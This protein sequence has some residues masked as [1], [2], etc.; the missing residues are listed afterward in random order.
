MSRTIKKNKIVRNVKLN[1]ARQIKIRNL[2]TKIETY[3]KSGDQLEADKAFS[4]ISNLSPYDALLFGELGLSLY[5][6]GRLEES[7]YLLRKV[8]YIKPNMTEIMT[9]LGDILVFH[10]RC[11]EGITFLEK[12]ISTN[13]TIPNAH[14]F[15]GE[16]L[17]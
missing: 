11:L 4:Q 5:R 1:K 16:G 12:A 3:L 14:R 9:L 8:L 7:L 10:D 6:W 15:L 2:L 13:P 17:Y